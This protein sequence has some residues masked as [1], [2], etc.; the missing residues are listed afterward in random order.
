MKV[1]QILATVIVE[2][3]VEASEIGKLC[4]H[5]EE[6]ANYNIRMSNYITVYTLDEIINY[7]DPP[8]DIN[9]N[10]YEKLYDKWMDESQKVIDR[11]KMEMRNP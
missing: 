5:L 9:D 4:K 8:S 1:Y 2:D 6:D 7:P 11:V 10:S 3:S